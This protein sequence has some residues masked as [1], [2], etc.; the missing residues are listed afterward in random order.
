MNIQIM[1]DSL[2]E[3]KNLFVIWKYLFD[4]KSS[5]SILEL[6]HKFSIFKDE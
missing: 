3:N 2:L 4:E 1:V 6:K 5:R